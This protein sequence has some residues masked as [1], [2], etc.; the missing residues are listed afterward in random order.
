MAN[1]KAK[2]TQKP[3]SKITQKRVLFLHTPAQR[4]IGVFGRIVMGV[5]LLF[6]L[7]A[8]MVVV[9]AKPQTAEAAAQQT[10]NFQGRLSQ[11]GGSTVPDGYYNVTF[12]LYAASSSGAQVWEEAHQDHNGA[13]AGQDYRVRVLKGRFTVS[14]G[15]IAPFPSTIDWGEELWMTIDVGGTDQVGLGSVEWT[16]EMSPRIKVPANAYA[17]KVEESKTLATTQGASTGTLGWQSLTANRGVSLPDADGVVCLRTSTAC[18][19]A[20]ATGG[21]GYIQNG[22]VQQAAT[23]F[24]VGG[25][26]QASTLNATTNLELNGNDINTAGTLSSVAYLNAVTTFKTTADNANAFQ[27]QTTSGTRVLGVDTVSNVVNVGVARTTE[28]FSLLVNQ[29]NPSN[30]LL[31]SAPTS[32]VR[33]SAWSPSGTYL[34]I[35]SGS[36]TRLHIYK[37]SGDTFTKLSVTTPTG[38]VFGVTW[39]PDGQYLTAAHATTPFVTTYKRSGD[40]FTKLADLT[41]G[42]LIVGTAR[43]ADWSPDGRYLSVA[44]LGGDFATIYRRDGDVLTKLSSALTSAGLPPNFGYSTAWSPDGRY[45]SVGHLS[46]PFVSV[47]KRSGERF[48]KLQNPASL[49]APEA[50]ATTYVPAVT[51]SPDGSHLAVATY[52]SAPNPGISIYKLANDGLSRITPTGMD[53]GVTGTFALAYSPDGSRLLITGDSGPGRIVVLAR[54][55]DAYSLSQYIAGSDNGR[56]LDW[57]PDGQYVVRTNLNTAATVFKI[58]NGVHADLSV[59]GSAYYAGEI[60][61]DSLVASGSVVGDTATFGS[62]AATSATI[63]S[64]TISDT[65]TANTT[66]T[67]ASGSTTPGLLTLG[68]RANGGDPS[69]VPDGSMYYNGN[70]NQFR[71][72]AGGQ[73]LNCAE[74][75]EGAAGAFVQNGNN[76]S[77]TA[78]LGTTDNYGLSVIVNSNEVANISAAGDI[79]FTPDQSF[80]V[81]D[82][83]SNTVLGVNTADNT[84][85]MDA[86]VD[87]NGI[88]S[89]NGGGL[90]VAGAASVGGNLTVT[91][92]TTISDNLTVQNGLS[93]DVGL[94]IVTVPGDLVVGGSMSGD[95][96]L[97]GNPASAT[98]SGAKFV[99]TVAE[100]QT[101]LRLGN[102]TSGVSWNDII[103]GSGGGKL[104]L[105]GD[106][107]NARAI[108]LT[109]EYTGAVI[110]GSGLGTMTTAYDNTVRR[111][112]YQWTATSGSSQTYDVV[113]RVGLP[114]D[115]S[116]WSA[117]SIC[118]DSWSSNTTNSYTTL[119][120]KDPGGANDISGQNI[121]PGSASTW[122]NNCYALDSGDYDADGVMTIT[123]TLR[124]QSSS[125]LRIGNLQLN[126]LSAF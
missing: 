78:V 20:P 123:L 16:G 51:W 59:Q 15:V 96:L 72:K 117:Q 124:A 69:G 8:V 82:A 73:W 58:G 104:R 30:P 75:D 33:P 37:K 63:Q 14:L 74:N 55:G 95:T 126:Y 100:V 113:V 23:D 1:T 54:S 110:T 122:S 43:S 13:T 7:I 88:L 35:G 18:S 120:V 9:A 26:G 107:R 12:R 17:F 28:A 48:S 22:T 50:N 112:Y 91:G 114:S 60:V 94:G 47:Y 64:L 83:S 57:S 102:A 97:L 61:A 99:T 76:F 116:E 40:T 5:L 53:T 39:S 29:A 121:V 4:V 65:I 81:N 119:G 52:F 106:A 10:I 85:T 84:V 46:S 3:M 27:V 71:C 89:V 41:G 44:H 21:T 79:V 111:T 67:L 36:A 49:P 92:T 108:T 24:S 118:L 31:P 80:A 11:P 101:V 2:Q 125:V 115:W 66:V 62:L 87:V 109:P 19:F 105:Y 34:A 45:L 38:D 42:N 103:T 32:S 68:V 98:L 77:A 6:V 86:D 90:T 70:S 56:G 93:V 25:T